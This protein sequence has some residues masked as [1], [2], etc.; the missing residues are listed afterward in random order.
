MNNE[1]FTQHISTPKIGVLLNKW[2]QR[3]V[4]VYEHPTDKNLVVSVGYPTDTDQNP[5]K[6]E[7]IVCVE[8]R[9]DWARAISAFP[10][11]AIYE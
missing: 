10:K 2:R 1:G 7:P 8:P 5:T 11:T 6:G 9:R 4:F 3:L